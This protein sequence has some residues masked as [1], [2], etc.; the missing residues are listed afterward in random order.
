MDLP[1]WTY[2]T[3][4]TLVCDTRVLLHALIISN[5]GSDNGQV[6]IY[7]GT[8]YTHPKVI[9]IYY[10]R[11]DTKVIIF[12]KPLL[13]DRGLYVRLYSNTAG[14]MVQYEPLNP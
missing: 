2:V 4:N 1:R 9:D 14:V 11:Y 7:N 3:G 6:M 13:L 12:E 8:Y 5:D 10:L